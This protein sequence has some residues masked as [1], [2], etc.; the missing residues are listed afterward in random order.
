MA[1]RVIGANNPRFGKE[2]EME[3]LEQEEY[4]YD[5]APTS[6]G[7]GAGGQWADFISQVMDMIQSGGW[8][9]DMMGGGD[10]IFGKGLTG[11]PAV[12]QDPRPGGAGTNASIAQLNPE[13]VKAL[14]PNDPERLELIAQISNGLLT[15]SPELI[16][17]LLKGTDMRMLQKVAGGKE[18]QKLND[19]I[20]VLERQVK[21]DVI[22]GVGL[23]AKQIAGIAQ[24]VTEG[25]VKGQ[26]PVQQAV[27]KGNLEQQQPVA[28]GSADQQAVKKALK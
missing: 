25:I 15:A 16:V 18:G 6:V 28:S 1:Q 20:G 26:K 24:G 19:Q 9:A 3:E 11:I 21:Q 27:L 14:A 22:P 8:G 13:Q 12:A 2:D 17:E 10:K 7:G 5:Q 23:D 4:G